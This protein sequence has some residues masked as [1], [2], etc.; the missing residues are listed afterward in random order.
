MSDTREQ[1]HEQAINHW[2]ERAREGRVEVQEANQHIRQERREDAAE[3]RD[4]IE[5]RTRRRSL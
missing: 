1:R 2:R 4:E 5:Q 3:K